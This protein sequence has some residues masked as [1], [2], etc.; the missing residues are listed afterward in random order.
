MAEEVLVT[1]FRLHDRISAGMKRMGAE[2]RSFTGQMGKLKSNIAGIALPM[3]VAAGGIA[4]FADAASKAAGDREAL[5]KGLEAYAGSAENLAYQLEVLKEAA[6]AP[7]LGF[8]EAI[9]GAVRLQ[10]AGIGFETA[11]SAIT[12]FGNALALVGGGKA[13][14]DGVLLALTQIAAKGKISAE[15]L[16]QIQERVPQ[17]RQVV[18]QR[19]GTSDTEQLQRM[20][21]TSDRFIREIVAGLAALPRSGN[22]IKNERENIETD[23]NEAFISIGNEINAVLLPLMRQFGKELNVLSQSGVVQSF[24]REVMGAVGIFGEK[25]V[26]GAMRSFIAEL[27]TLPV[28]IENFAQSMSA[29]AD[30]V[31]GTAAFNK[32]RVAKG[33]AEMQALSENMGGFENILQM[34]RELTMKRLTNAEKEFLKDSGPVERKPGDPVQAAM[35]QVATNTRKLVDLQ[36]RQVDLSEQILGGGT[37][38]RNA[39]S[40]VNLTR[41]MGGLNPGASASAKAQHHLNEAVKAILAETIGLQIAAVRT[42][43]N[44]VQVR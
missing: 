37:A 17:I 40:Q 36:Q 28:R 41:A 25:D 35:T 2:V 20:G 42:G 38:G 21:V 27:S 22:S 15:E 5:L 6:K 26:K 11:A 8:Q 7:G 23:I 16:L 34:T 29:A 12:Q 31:L 4:L 32:E 9:Q 44:R 24:T 13:E 33:I 3:A 14:L 1:E 30:I 18:A 19:F 39:A 43:G 10:A